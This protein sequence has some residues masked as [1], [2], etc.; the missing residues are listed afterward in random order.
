LP[1][2]CS[3]TSRNVTIPAGCSLIQNHRLGNGPNA[4]PEISDG[5]FGTLTVT[6]VDQPIEAFV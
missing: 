5:C 6:S 2:T 4:V 1:N 3:L